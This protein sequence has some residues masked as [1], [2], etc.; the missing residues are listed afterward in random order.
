MYGNRNLAAAGIYALNHHVSRLTTDHLHA[1]LLAEALSQ[2]SVINSVMKVET[3][4]KW[5]RFMK[6]TIKIAY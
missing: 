3:I 4:L 1:S 2:V 5:H 6:V